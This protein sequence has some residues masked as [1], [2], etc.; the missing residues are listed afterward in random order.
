L[1]ACRSN[2]KPGGNG[3]PARAQFFDSFFPGHLAFD[4]EVPIACDA[5]IDFIAFP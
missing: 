5:N 3:L 1:A 4:D 2:W